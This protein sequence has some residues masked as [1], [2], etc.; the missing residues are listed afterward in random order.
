MIKHP[1]GTSMTKELL[2]EACLKPGAFVL[3]L[4]AGD[5][6]TVALLRSLGFNAE[7]VDLSPGVGVISGDITAL[8]F[9]DEYYD[10]A[11]AECTFSVCGNAAAAFSEARRVLSPSG[12]LMLSDVYYKSENAPSLSLPCPAVK[13]GWIETAD[14]FELVHFADRTDVWTEYIIDCV[15][16]GKD[17]GDCGFYKAAVKSKC[18]Y[19][20][21]VWKKV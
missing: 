12:I 14:G 11:I 17:I 15:W 3:D 21:S 9:P 6:E 1:D 16:H 2:S 10:A 5:G 4:G 18:G 7:G 19:F 13:D 8:P 20:I